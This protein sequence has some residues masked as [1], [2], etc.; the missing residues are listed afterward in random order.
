MVVATGLSRTPLIGRTVAKQIL[1]QQNVSH[2]E[3]LF[4]RNL[5]RVYAVCD[6][7]EFRAT[8]PISFEKSSSLHTQS[9]A[10][11]VKQMFMMV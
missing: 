1:S 8:S 11:S 7:N 6:Q 2:S 10:G 3:L 9:L 4:F 5:L